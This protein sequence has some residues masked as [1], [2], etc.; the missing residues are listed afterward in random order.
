[1]NIA[2]H[3]ATFAI[4]AMLIHSLTLLDSAGIKPARLALGHGIYSAHARNLSFP[5]LR[6]GLS[7]LEV[8]ELRR[9]FAGVADV[10]AYRVYEA[11]VFAAARKEFVPVLGFGRDN[12]PAAAN[13]VGGAVLQQGSCLTQSGWGQFEMVKVDGVACRVESGQWNDA[14]FRFLTGRQ[15]VV[16]VRLLDPREAYFHP[17]NRI[18]E[19]LLIGRNPGN[20][21]GSFKL[22]RTVPTELAVLSMEEWFW[23]SQGPLVL[24]LVVLAGAVGFSGL[25]AMLG[26]GLAEAAKQREGDRIR[27]SL[28]ES[29]FRAWIRY[30][31]HAAGQTL[32]VSL[33]LILLHQGQGVFLVLGIAFGLSGAW[34]VGRSVGMGELSASHYETTNS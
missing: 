10:I 15:R 2:N 26:L 24:L 1:M 33:A 11:E 8:E 29:R 30:G 14:A 22:D 28:G 25:M 27:S 31:S 16:M 13:L 4:G 7:G 21:L 32:L 9:R 3:L 19:A 20:R 34:L 12:S 23:E 6:M 18:Y 17:E 5:Q